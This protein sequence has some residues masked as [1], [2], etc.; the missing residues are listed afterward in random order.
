MDVLFGEPSLG[1][2]RRLAAHASRRDG[3]AIDAVGAVARDED[4]VD[5]RGAAV[6]VLQ[7]DV[8]LGVQFQ[9]IFEVARG[10]RVAVGAELAAAR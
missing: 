9:L 2:D 3:L 4:A 1:I 5:A 7:F 10:G 6:G 8:S